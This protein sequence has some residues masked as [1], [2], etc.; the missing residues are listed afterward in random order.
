MQKNLLAIEIVKK[1]KE[2]AVSKLGSPRYKTTPSVFFSKNN[3]SRWLGVERISTN[4]LKIYLQVIASFLGQILLLQ[5]VGLFVS[6]MKNRRN[7]RVKK[8]FLPT[9]LQHFKFFLSRCIFQK[10]LFEICKTIFEFKK[11]PWFIFFFFS[12]AQLHCVRKHFYFFNFEK[13]LQ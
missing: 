12:V 6:T 4:L 13:K 1:R 9:P 2:P 11:T 5:L 10:N 8:S 3:I 7:F